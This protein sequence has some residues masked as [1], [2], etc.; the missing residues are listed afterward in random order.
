MVTFSTAALWITRPTKG[1]LPLADTPCLSE[2]IWVTPQRNWEWATARWNSETNIK[3]EEKK[4]AENNQ[5]CTSS[6]WS[7]VEVSRG[8]RRKTC[9]GCNVWLS[10]RGRITGRMIWLTTSSR[11]RWNRYNSCAG[12]VK[13]SINYTWLCQRRDWKRSERRRCR[14]SSLSFIWGLEEERLMCLDISS[15]FFPKYEMSFSLLSLSDKAVFHNTI[16]FNSV[17]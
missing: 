3:S 10:E 11:W 14:V 13:K 17:F 2:T 9:S 8:M 1:P 7:K 5:R 4:K 15:R 16:S 12:K 6:F